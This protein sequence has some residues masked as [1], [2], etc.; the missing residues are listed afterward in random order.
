MLFACG[1]NHNKSTKALDFTNYNR[2]NFYLG[3]KSLPTN[4]SQKSDFLRT[5]FADQWIAIDEDNGKPFYGTSLNFVRSGAQTAFSMVL[6]DNS[7]PDGVYTENHYIGEL[8]G[9][10]IDEPDLIEWVFMKPGQCGASKAWFDGIRTT[11]L[12][13]ELKIYFKRNCGSSFQ[14]YKMQRNVQSID[15]EESWTFQKRGDI[16][17]RLRA[18][19]D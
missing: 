8:H 19:N 6:P 1:E 11:S 9:H 13:T 12:G 2:R 10:S 16:N 5:I 7:G 15:I 14:A 17:R 4:N 18:E 3:T